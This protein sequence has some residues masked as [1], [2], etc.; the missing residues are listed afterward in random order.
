MRKYKIFIIFI[1][2][3]KKT[4]INND[5]KK[6]I[7]LLMINFELSFINNNLAINP[8]LSKVQYISNNNSIREKIALWLSKHTKH[9]I[10][11]NQIL[12]TNGIINTIQLLLCKYSE[13]GDTIIVNNL[14]S[15]N[16]CKIFDEFGLDVIIDN[17]DIETKI[18]SMQEQCVLFYYTDTYNISKN[19]LSELCNTYN[20]LYII[21]DDTSYFLSES[22]IQCKKQELVTDYHPKI[23]SIGCFSKLLSPSINVGWIYQNTSL[24]NYKLDYSFIEGPSGLN[25]SAILEAS[26]K[27]VSIETL[28]VEFILDNIIDTNIK[29]LAEYY[30]LN[31]TMLTEYLEQFNHIDI[32]QHN[33]GSYILILLKTIKNMNNFLKLCIKNGISFAI[34]SNNYIKLNYS[35]YNIETLLYGIDVMIDCIKKYNSINIIFNESCN[36]HIKNIL[37]KNQDFNIDPDISSYNNGF[38]EGYDIN[39]TVIIDTNPDVKLYQLLL[40]EKIYIPILIHTR[41]LSDD[42]MSII[43]MYKLYA[44]VAHISNFSEGYNI[45]NK[46]LEITKHLSWN[47]SGTSE[48]SNLQN[49]NIIELTNGIDSIKFEFNIEFH[50]T[51]YIYW[52]LTCPNGFYTNNLSNIY[53]IKKNNNTLYYLLDRELSELVSI[54][55]MKKIIAK[56]NCNIVHIN[57]RTTKNTIYNINIHN[58]DS[59]YKLVSSLFDIIDFVK[60]KSGIMEISYFPKKEESIIYKFK[61]INDMIMI[62]IPDV[63]YMKEDNN[64]ISEIIHTMTDL[65][66]LGINKYNTN[67]NYLVLEVKENVLDNQMLDTVSMLI[68]SSNENKQIIFINYN[69]YED[70]TFNVRIFNSITNTEEYNNMETYSAVF[71]YYLYNFA[72]S[73]DDY[74]KLIIKLPNNNYVNLIYYK[75][76]TYIYKI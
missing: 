71:E 61:N 27:F 19:K 60:N 57:K 29:K 59:D 68:N 62:C 11:M 9:D 14:L 56:H 7:I 10:T 75:D 32:I 52:L 46:I 64:S 70:N 30:K 25:Q 39:N 48:I 37:L 47:I 3:N 6:I 17:D 38:F 4:D 50:I 54:Y 65:T 66:L 41:L 24:P 42:I 63:E 16:I 45:L 44:P 76:E 13:A 58:I 26:G 33:E 35:Y 23:I 74:I 51:Q 8:E 67:S 34:Y 5:Y 28:Y 72:K 31:C 73:Y 53:N 1:L 2:F 20:N 22:F 18:E 21:V 43:D 15:K 12:I 49:H 36:S 55:E 69:E 40:K